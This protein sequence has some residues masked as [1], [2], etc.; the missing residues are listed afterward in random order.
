M[1]KV[2]EKEKLKKQHSLQITQKFIWKTKKN[3]KGLLPG[4]ANKVWRWY[5]NRWKVMKEKV[6]KR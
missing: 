3:Q 1:W 5:E 2:F 4:K 6:E